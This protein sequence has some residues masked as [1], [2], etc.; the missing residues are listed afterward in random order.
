MTCICLLGKK[1]SIA[2]FPLFLNYQ[3]QVNWLL[4]TKVNCEAPTAI[5]AKFMRLINHNCKQISSWIKKNQ[6]A[7]VWLL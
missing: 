3:Y 5:Y 2:E 1:I 4:Q 6:G 7:S